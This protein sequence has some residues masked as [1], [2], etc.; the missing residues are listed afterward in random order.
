FPAG[1]TTLGRQLPVVAYGDVDA[2][3]TMWV[4]ARQHP[5]ETPAS[6]AAEG[7]LA[8]LADAEDPAV[9]TL[10]GRARVLVAPLVDLDGAHLGNHRTNAAGVDLNRTWDDPDRAQAPEIAALRR[11][12]DAHGVD[13]FLDL[14]ADESSP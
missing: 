8:R 11:A 5:G 10:L 3:R 13:L 7:L 6:W 14:H 4:V 1:A 12:I 9:R 2:P